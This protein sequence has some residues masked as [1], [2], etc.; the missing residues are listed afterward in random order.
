MEE[1]D[2]TYLWMVV[3]SFIAITMAMVFGIMG[4]MELRSQ[5]TISSN[6][7]GS[8][9]SSAPASSSAK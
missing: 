8:S 6:G 3:I 2:K 1:N 4:L 7:G 5:D 9:A